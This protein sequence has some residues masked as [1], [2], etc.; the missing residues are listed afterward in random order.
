MVIK[1]TQQVITLFID[2][3]LF[4][5]MKL[6]PGQKAD[7]KVIFVDFEN[8]N[9]YHRYFYNL[10]K[11]FKIAGYKIIYPMNFSKFRN[12][13][14]GDVY[15][16]LM[17]Q[18]KGFLNI[19][20][21]IPKE[22]YIVLKDDLFSADYYKRYF[23]NENQKLDTF[24]VPMSFHP[25]MYHKNLWQLPIE[26]HKRIN[27]IYSFGNFDRD[28]YKAIHKAPFDIINRAEL[29]ES[30]AT[31]DGFI[32]INTKAELHEL[33]NNNSNYRY[34]FV[35]KDNC[36]IRMENL[37]IHLAKFRY[38]LCCPGV[39]AP[40]S[41]NFTEAL[42][43]GTVPIIQKSYADL[44]YPKLEHKKNAFIFNDWEDLLRLTDKV[45]FNLEDEEYAEMHQNAQKYY[46]DFL[47]PKSVAK[48]IINNINHSKIFLNASER[49]VKRIQKHRIMN[50]SK[51]L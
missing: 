40:L 51:V 38:F 4:L 27:A 31:Q 44:I 28:A 3:F 41:H 5:K 8:P 2:F 13:R 19:K 24:H 23:I 6:L 26:K 47:H 14:N 43:V 45:I 1:R 22:N 49:S 21:T 15:L 10:L 32:S 37:R 34:V 18:E 30:F 9:L 20:N 29:I 35:E 16:A 17:F 36:Q 7:D 25:Y 48:N 46:D 11:T 39:F 42:S 50:S 12:L 33:I